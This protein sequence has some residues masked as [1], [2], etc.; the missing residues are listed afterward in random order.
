MKVVQYASVEK[1]YQQFP[2]IRKQDVKEL[3]LWVKT[4]LHLPSVSELELIQFLQSNE[5]DTEAAKR[6]IEVFFTFRSSYKDFFHDRD[7]YAGPVQRSMDVLS[8]VILPELTPLGYHVLLAK[9]VDSDASKF[10]LA[11]LLKLAFMCVDVALWEE[12]CTEGFLL[13]IDMSGLHLGHFPK[14]GIFTLKNFLYYIQEA[15]PIRLKGVHLINV[16][17]FIDKIVAMVK[18]FLKKEILEIFH[19]HQKEDTVYPHIPQS[20][21]PSEYGGSSP[22]RSVLTKQLFDKTLE[23]RDFILEK[24]RAQKVDESKRIKTRSLTN[25]FGLF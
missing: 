5:Y 15:L 14:L 7:I 24:E 12:G 21:L 17:P 20:I 4:Q 23:L 25:M 13:V 3:D 22:S 1:L 8:L 6:T 19:L 16:V 11:T 10:N 2:A 18:P 9:I